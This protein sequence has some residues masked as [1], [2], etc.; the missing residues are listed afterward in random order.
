MLREVCG[1]TAAEVTEYVLR[2]VL[3]LA[4]GNPDNHGRNTAL[5]KDIDGCVRLTP[6]F[7]FCPMRLDASGVRRST[8]WGC[9]REPLGP[10]RDLDPDRSVVATSRPRPS[11]IRRD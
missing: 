10:S 9:M 5:A 4:L 11:W 1:D 3:N 7:D 2:D 8:T 6:L